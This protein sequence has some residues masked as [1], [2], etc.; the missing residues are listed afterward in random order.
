M[1]RRSLDRG[2]VLLVAPQ[3]VDITRVRVHLHRMPMPIRRGRIHDRPRLTVIGRPPDPVGER[4]VAGEVVVRHD[5]GVCPVGGHRV[6][7]QHAVEKRIVQNRRPGL[8]AVTRAVEVLVVVDEMREQRSRRKH[9]ETFDM[10]V[11]RKVVQ[12]RPGPPF[13]ERPIQPIFLH[14][15]GAVGQDAVADA[16]RINPEC[17][18]VGVREHDVDPNRADRRRHPEPAERQKNDGARRP[19]HQ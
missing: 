1:I 8:A 10:R 13:I 12:R 16:V 7:R 4:S 9:G 17:D 2:H 3:H 6:R 11:R 5:V 18:V 19:P 15:I 14:R